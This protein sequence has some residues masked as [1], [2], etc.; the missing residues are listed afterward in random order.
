MRLRGHH[1]KSLTGQLRQVLW[2][3]DLRSLGIMACC[4]AE[5]PVLQDSIFPEG[6]GWVFLVSHAL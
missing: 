3:R 1:A 2:T 6:S 4:C 5:W